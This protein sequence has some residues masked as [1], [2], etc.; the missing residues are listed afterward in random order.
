[1]R[2]YFRRDLRWRHTRL[3][4][5]EYRSTGRGALVR[6]INASRIERRFPMKIAY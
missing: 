1:M 3:N 2:P 5:I 6:V 4:Q